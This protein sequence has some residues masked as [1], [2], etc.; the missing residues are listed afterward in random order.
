[1][2]GAE[3]SAVAAAVRG[4]SHCIYLCGALGLGV[5]PTEVSSQSDEVRFCG[6]TGSL[7]AHY[8]SPP[9]EW[10]LQEVDGLS[11]GRCSTNTHRGHGGKRL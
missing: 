6:T 3:L 8:P 7:D 4:L 9:L 5:Q 2:L 11:C 10:K 1:M